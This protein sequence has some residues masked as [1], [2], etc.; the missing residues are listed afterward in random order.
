M[1]KLKNIL[2]YTDE[3]DYYFTPTEIDFKRKQ[4][5]E[6]RGTATFCRKHQF[7]HLKIA[8]NIPDRTTTHRTVEQWEAEEGMKLPEDSAVWFF[9]GMWRLMLY[10]NH[11]SMTGSYLCVVYEHPLQPRPA[12]DWRPEKKLYPKNRESKTRN[13]RLENGS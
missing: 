6:R 11:K 8:N 12:D 3:M 2:L 13:K 4:V 5:S 9:I 1:D 10:G 7:K